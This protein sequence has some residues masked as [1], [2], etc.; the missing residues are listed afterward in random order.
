MSSKL[1]HIIT[2]TTSH[3][4]SV[5]PD[6]IENLLK[7]NYIRTEEISLVSSDIIKVTK[8]Y[9]DGYCGQQ[10]ND[11]FSGRSLWFFDE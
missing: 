1:W 4:F 10:P 3:N 9:Y 5:V 11:G 2:Y 7:F 8:F 6:H